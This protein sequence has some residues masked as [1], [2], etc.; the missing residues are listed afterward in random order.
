MGTVAGLI[1]IGF[2]LLMK[3]RFTVA[4]LKLTHLALINGYTC[5]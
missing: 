2:L 5:S 3:R 4:E 1:F